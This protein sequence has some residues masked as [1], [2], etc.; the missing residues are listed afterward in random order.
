MTTTTGIPDA[1]DAPEVPAPAAP[2]RRDAGAWAGIVGFGILGLFLLM[3]VGTAWYPYEVTQTA[4]APL[5]PPSLAHPLGTT[6]VG[7]DVLSHLLA[8]A[9][10]SLT[11]AV[12]SGSVS[13]LLGLVIGMAAG[14]NGGGRLDTALMGVVD[15]ILVLPRIPLL[16]VVGVFVGPG[17][18]AIS[19]IMAAVFWPGTAR[20]VRSQVLSLRRRTH[21]LAARG[22]GG[23]GLHAL[24]RHVVPEITLLL[25][26]SFIGAA[27]R[28][29]T[30]EAGLA[31]LG[32]GS[33]SRASWGSMLDRA[34]S[35]GGLFFSAAWAWW[36]LP[37]VMALVLFLVSLALIGMA[38]ERYLHPRVARHRG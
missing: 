31:F 21:L 16:V 12:I 37:A 22:F 14:W 19:L 34:T 13:V 1:P 17:L 20:V 25:V 28:A 33:P 38:A 24:R 15:V 27:G 11:V 32:L 4:G 7:F 8:G 35:F 30:F 18:V 6:A 23:G 3:A 9:R 5:E 26:A 10:V 2:R 29:V 36:L